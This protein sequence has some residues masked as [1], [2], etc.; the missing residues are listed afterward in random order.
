MKH[1]DAIRKFLKQRYLN[2]HRDW[3]ADLGRDEAR[4]P[5]EIP[6]G[7]PTEQMAQQNMDGALKWINSWRNWHGSGIVTWCE[8]RWRVLGTQQL[9]EKIILGGPE[10]VVAWIGEQARWKQACDR[11][12]ALSGRWPTLAP[13][14]PRHFDVLA[15][16]SNADFTR[17][18]DMLAWLEAH[19]TSNLYS[20]QIP[21]AGLDSKWLEGRQSL[22]ASLLAGI[23]C[24]T[25]SNSDF[26]QQT[27]LQP[28]PRL[29]RLRI[30]DSGLRKVVG[31]LGDITAPVE[32]LACLNLPATKIFIVENLQTGLAFTDMPGAVVIMRLG[33]NVDVLG[34]LPWIKKADCIYWGD[35]DTHGFGILHRARAYLPN[36]RSVLMD[37]ATLLRYQ[38]LWGNEEKQHSAEELMLLTSEEQ[39]LYKILKTQDWEQN[40][41]LEQER[42]AWDYAWERLQAI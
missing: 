10:E 6:L 32:D 26:F 23:K 15:D 36:L 29:M 35:I 39:A 5:M 12:K 7:L 30:L 3:L 8:R 21:V 2:Q 25:T 42:I 40:V 33:Y 31:G 18:E 17:L 16:Y 22:I 41:R 27:G 9:P 24:E 19:P 34:N 1:P 28:M 11:Y 13:V 4:W 37:Q 38:D 14:L 20:R